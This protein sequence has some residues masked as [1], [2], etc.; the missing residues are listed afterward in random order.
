MK[1]DA[2]LQTDVMAHLKWD[3]SVHASQIGVIAHNGVVTLVGEVGSYGEKLAAERI[4]QQVTGVT[5]LAIDLTV[6]LTQFGRRTDAD[7]ARAAENIL[8]WTDGLVN[9]AARVMV[10]DGL[11]TLSG[12]VEWQFQKQAAAD[13]IRHLAGV[14]GIDNQMQIQPKLTMSGLKEGI[15]QALMRR[16]STDADVIGV[17]VS[18][19]DV[20][21]TGTVRSWGE[22]ELA[23]RCAWGTPGVRNVVDKMTLRF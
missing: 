3:P 20:T 1:T 6:T 11:V 13:A 18:G 15:E 8:K 4:A 16:A 21:L 2:Q 22:R 19:N 7:I 12:A 23:N 9:E 5:A 14:I 10:E 17:D